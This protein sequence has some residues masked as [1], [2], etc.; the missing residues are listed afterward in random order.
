[1]KRLYFLAALCALASTTFA[2]QP[3]PNDSMSVKKNNDTIR[4]GNILIIKRRLKTS[5]NDS[6]T[7]M[8]DIDF[9]KKNNRKSTNYAVFDL[10][11]ANWTDNTNYANTGSFVVNKPGANPFSA[12]DLKPRGGKSINVNIWFFMQKYALVKRNINL[13]YGLGLELNNYHFRSPISFK[14]GGPVPYSVGG[15]IANAPFVFRDTITFSKNKL[16]ADYL[17]VPVMLNFAT[18]RKPGRPILSASFGVSAGYLYSQRNKQISNERG[19][20]KNKGDYNMERFKLSYIG[21]LGLGSVRL[22][23][24]YSPKSIFEKSFD[25]RPYN[26]GIRFSNW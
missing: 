4:I 1:M 12:D 3:T 11:F 10:G 26:I 13:K 25:L 9:K 18:N 15:V 17:T 22:Y 7:V 24:S 6:T 20:Q 23:G 2:Q 21:E 14:E 5:K 19:K 16:A 8:A